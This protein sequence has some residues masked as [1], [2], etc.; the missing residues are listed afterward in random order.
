M[1]LKVLRHQSM[2][3]SGKYLLRSIQNENLP[4]VDL[5]IRECLQN[6]LDAASSSKAGD[7]VI[8]NAITGSCD[9]KAVNKIFREL[10]KELDKRFSA[11]TVD[12]I[13]IKD[14]NTEGLTGPLRESELTME[15]DFGNLRKLIYEFGQPQS[16]EGKGGSWGVGKTVCFRIGTGI[17]LYYSRIKNEDGS[18]S[19]RMAGTLI[20]NETQENSLIRSAG[21]KDGNVSAGIAWWGGTDEDGSSMPVTDEKEIRQILSVFAI[22]PYEGTETGTCII[23]PY[24]RRQDLE[25]NSNRAGTLNG[26]KLE[27]YLKLAVQRWYFPRLRNDEYAYGP[28]LDFRVNNTPLRS[29]EEKVFFTKMQ[30]LYNISSLYIKNNIKKEGLPAG[31]YAE[32]IKMNAT[33]TGSPVAGVVVYTKVTDQELEMVPPNN[34]PIPYALLNKD[35]EDDENGNLAIIGYCRKAGMVISYEIDSAWTRG[36]P[37][38]PEGEFLLAFFQPFGDKKLVVNDQTLDEYLRSTENADHFSWKDREVDGRTM[39]IVEKI[40]KRIPKL[41]AATF[42]DS[43][44]D[45]KLKSDKA[46][47]KKLGQ[48]FLPPQGYGRKASP[49]RQKADGGRQTIKSSGIVMQMADPSYEAANIMAIKYSLRVNAGIR[50]LRIFFKAHTSQVEI[51]ADK[52]E[53][54]LGTP[55]PIQVLKDSC[56]AV[57]GDGSAVHFDPMETKKQRCYGICLQGMNHDEKT[58][59]GGVIKFIC[60]DSGI[61]VRM[62]TEKGA[63]NE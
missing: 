17:V 42:E 21:L 1:E 41:I 30:E 62:L 48:S 12:F 18:F 40:V 55:F 27:D 16:A 4:R 52:W 19:S 10:S 53:I 5:L 61:S 45:V 43:V 35:N 57:T 36:I 2:T 23:I 60:R 38:Q 47:Q 8:I 31:I 56:T 25:R 11:D 59:I 29:A 58:E 6:S 24:I 49:G 46:L 54:D 28:Y 15:G 37:I 22:P 14:S 13:A 50:K 3:Q 20:E 44:E 33:F 51:S 63:E 32:E 26:L 9:K 39:T 34:E 7:K